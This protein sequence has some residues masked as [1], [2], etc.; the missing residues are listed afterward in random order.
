[1]K[2]SAVLTITSLL[3]VVLFSLHVAD[4]IARG[5]DTIGP[6]S[7]IGV[8]IL[9]VWLCGALVLSGR[10]S[11]LIILLLGAILGLGVV[12]L[13]MNGKGISRTATSSGG[14]FYVWTLFTFGATSFVSLVLSVKGLWSLRR[15][16]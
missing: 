3:S 6:S 8:L 2:P 11:G 13:H 16:T 12:V 4:D 5:L 9:G 15:S 14:I 7:P 1:M 10:R